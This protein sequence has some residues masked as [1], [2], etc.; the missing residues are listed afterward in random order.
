M[1]PHGD[2]QRY[3]NDRRQSKA[4][5]HPPHRHADVMDEVELCEQQPTFLRHRDRAGQERG[6]DVAAQGEEPP[7]SKKQHEKPQAQQPLRARAH[8]LQWSE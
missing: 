4:T 1:R 3:R 7:D 8:G 2:A 5:E 6:R